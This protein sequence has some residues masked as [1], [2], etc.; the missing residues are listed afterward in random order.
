[1]KKHYSTLRGALMESGMTQHDLAHELGMSPSSLSN[2]FTGKVPWTTQEAY[3]V[4]QVLNRTDSELH[5]YFPPDSLSKSHCDC[6]LIVKESPV[7]ASSRELPKAHTGA[8]QRREL[9]EENCGICPHRGGI[10]HANRGEHEEG[11]AD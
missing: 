6:E 3:S 8:G 5:V 7:R 10:R 11:L 9:P 4:L 1:M 2:R